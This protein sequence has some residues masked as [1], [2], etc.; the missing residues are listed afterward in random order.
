MALIAVY[1]LTAGLSWGM[2]LAFMDLKRKQ[3]LINGCGAAAAAGLVTAGLR[4]ADMGPAECLSGILV[5]FAGML[6][7]VYVQ[8]GHVWA[9]A[10]AAFFLSAGAC[11]ILLSPFGT[12]EKV[13]LWE[14]GTWIVFVLSFAA[15]CVKFHGPLL[16]DEWRQYYKKEWERPGKPRL[17]IYYVYMIII[18][19]GVVPAVGLFA[20]GGK[21]GE[22]RVLISVFSALMYWLGI[23][24]VTLMNTS[25]K[26]WSA[27]LAEQQYREEMEN[28][29]NVIRS[30]RH[31]Y[32]FHVQTIAG[33]IHS[34]KIQ[35]CIQYVDDLERDA[36]VMN[37]VLPIKDAAISALIHNFQILAAR[38]GIEL[39]IDIQNDLS[40]IAT[41]VYETNKIIS[42]LLQN[43]LDE[44]MTHKDKSYGIRLSVLKRGE[45][46]VIRVSNALKDAMD[47]P[48][49]IGKIY[50][51][52]Y[53]TKQGHEG[54][55]LSSIRTLASRYHGVIYTQVEDKIIHF[56][57]RIPINYARA[58]QGKNT[59]FGEEEKV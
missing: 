17:K 37:A 9:D 4:W 39:H 15:A 29:M 14:I 45:Y 31:D 36:S 28:F 18:L 56:V 30:Q 40:Q 34:G 38:E 10:V 11:S 51:Q 49:E 53:S 54:V 46:C 44:T 21:T 8:N 48:G 19:M 7:A 41:N 47:D 59:A 2:S 6:A 3:I 52:G 20:C 22:V 16:E 42:N 43:A 33:L 1:V 25:Q 58:S 26:E 50:Q 24:C 35:E 55:G 32:N 57:A 27:I 5:V 13:E 12:F 23:F